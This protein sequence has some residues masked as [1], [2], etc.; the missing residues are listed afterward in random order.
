MKRLLLFLLLCFAACTEDDEKSNFIRVEVNEPE[1]NQVFSAGDN[2]Q[3]VANITTSNILKT[4]S[5]FIGNQEIKIKKFSSVGEHFIDTLIRVD[6]T[7]TSISVK[8]RAEDNVGNA[9]DKIMLNFSPYQ[10]PP[11]CVKINSVT[12]V[13]SFPHTTPDE[14]S[15]YIHGEF[16]GNKLADIN[17]KLV[18]IPGTIKCSCISMPTQNTTFQFNR[19]TQSTINQTN[20]CGDSYFGLLLHTPSSVGVVLDKWK[21]IDC[22]N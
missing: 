15:V 19:G 4:V 14:E 20:N 2:Y 18:P 3:L 22:I 1:L 10:L 9:E 11:P 5:I 8:V 16:N 6:P 13:A 17:Y 7:R 12:M 21:D